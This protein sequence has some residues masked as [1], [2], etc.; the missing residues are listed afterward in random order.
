MLKVR[1]KLSSSLRASICESTGNTANEMAMD[2]KPSGNWMRKVALVIQVMA[3][4]TVCEARLRSMTMPMF[5][6]MTLNTTGA[7]SRRIRRT[8]GWRKSI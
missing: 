5:C 7:Y 8:T 6:T 3:S 4:G 2:T 1:L